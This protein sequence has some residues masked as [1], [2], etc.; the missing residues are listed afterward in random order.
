MPN[1]RESA[2]RCV[3]ESRWRP[4]QLVGR[5]AA[6]D[7]CG[8]PVQ[9]SP[10]AR[11]L[12]SAQN[13]A[14]QKT[15]VRA[16]P[17]KR[18]RSR[19]GALRLARTRATSCQRPAHEA[20]GRLRATGFPPGQRHSFQEPRSSLH[21]SFLRVRGNGLYFAEFR[22]QRAAEAILAR[23]IRRSIQKS[24]ARPKIWLLALSVGVLELSKPRL[25]FPESGA[26]RRRSSSSGHRSPRKRRF[27]RKHGCQIAAERWRKLLEFLDRHVANRFAFLLRRAQ[28]VAHHFM[29]FAK[30][31]AARNQIIGEFGCDER[32]ILCGFAQPRF[33]E[34]CGRESR[35][36]D[37]RHG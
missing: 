21:V 9:F 13:P 18:A 33:V 31:Y 2:Q 30:W 35:G 1:H 28:H 22:L 25:K 3:R 6:S 32:G 29:R 27:E 15:L 19:D 34:F 23:R 7:M 17:R 4:P 16:L 20:P 36:G 12:T 8:N 37:L 10:S 5:S 14:A 24:H 11:A 26:N